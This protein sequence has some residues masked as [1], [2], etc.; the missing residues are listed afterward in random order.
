MWYW[1]LGVASALDTLGS[2][3]LGSGNASAVR[4]WTIVS[5]VVSV[6]IS[7]PMILILVFGSGPF[8]QY[9]LGSDAQTSRDV[10]NFCSLL[11]VGVLPGALTT[12]VQKYLTVRGI[13]RPVGGCAFFTL[14]LNLIFNQFFIHG[15]GG[16]WQGMG[17]LGSPIATSTSRIAQLLI[18]LCYCRMHP[19]FVHG[20][21][22]TALSDWN[23]PI[24][25]WRKLRSS[26]GGDKALRTYCKLGAEGG[27]MLVSEAMSFDVTCIYAA[28]L[29]KLPLDGRFVK[30]RKERWF[31]IIFYNKSCQKPYVIV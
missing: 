4:S 27:V 16:S 6:M 7:I 13:V 2:Q 5:A 21:D 22:P 31:I 14:F 17:M 11:A 30:K 12:T 26:P 24:S 18:L 10:G 28:L 23:D 3:S 20:D 8:A 9:A 15:F 19:Q 29:G 25:L 1:L